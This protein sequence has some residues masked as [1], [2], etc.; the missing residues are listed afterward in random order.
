MCAPTILMILT[1]D[2]HVAGLWV[3]L[4]RPELLVN[5]L[6]ALFVNYLPIPVVLLTEPDGTQ[7]VRIAPEAF[8]VASAEFPDQ[9]D[10]WQNSLPGPLKGKLQSVSTTILSSF[11]FLIASLQLSGAAVLSINDNPPFDAVNASAQITGSFQAFG[12]RQNSC[13]SFSTP[14]ILL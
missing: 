3:I 9:I 7:N 5:K 12:T 1:V 2:C 11:V 6:S 13:V 4:F 8:I 10:F 14:I